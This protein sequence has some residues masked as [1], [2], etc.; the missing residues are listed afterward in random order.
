MF[1]EGKWNIGLKWVN[2]FHANFLVLDP[3]KTSE[4]IWFFEAFNGY[5]NRTLA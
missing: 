3:L 2:S 1:T 4:N 5:R